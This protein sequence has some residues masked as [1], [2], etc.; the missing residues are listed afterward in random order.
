MSR[1]L[2]GII[3]P[4]NSRILVMMLMIF[5]AVSST[6]IAFIYAEQNR[7]SQYIQSNSL[8]NKALIQKAMNKI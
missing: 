2:G 8:A 7:L 1:I 5:F 4:L 6:G 3:V